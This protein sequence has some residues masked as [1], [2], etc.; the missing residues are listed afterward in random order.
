L[1]PV[2]LYTFDRDLRSGAKF[3]F[4]VVVF[5]PMVGGCY[6]SWVIVAEGGAAFDRESLLRL[7]TFPAYFTP[8]AN[9]NN[10]GGAHRTE[11]TGVCDASVSAWGN[12]GLVYGDLAV[13]QNEW[14]TKNLKEYGNSSRNLKSV[15]IQIY[16]TSAKARLCY[17]KKENALK[18]YTNE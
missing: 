16:A 4:E 3:N 12:Y 1:S 17:A 15:V 10:A 8:L 13:S 18:Q 5:Q 2:N 6:R 9:N 7:S 11:L 14:Y